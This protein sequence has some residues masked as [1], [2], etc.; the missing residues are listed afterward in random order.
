MTMIPLDARNAPFR[1]KYLTEETFLLNRWMIFGTYPDGSVCIS[2]GQEDIMEWVPRD[3]AERIIAARDAFCGV[4][5][6]ELGLTQE[7]LDAMREA[8]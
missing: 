8:L 7:K 3:Q 1:M 6:E 5:E 4:I 2:D